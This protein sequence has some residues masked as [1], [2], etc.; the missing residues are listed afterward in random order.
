MSRSK[1]HVAKKFFDWVHRWFGLIAGFYFV[2][3]GLSGSFLVYEDDLHDIYDA[4]MRISPVST[5]APSLSGLV[6]ALRDHLGDPNAVPNRLNIPERDNANAIFRVE[7]KVDGEKKQ[8]TVFGDPASLKITGEEFYRDTISGFVFVFHHDLFWGSTG[9]T[10][11][12]VSGTLMLILLVTGLYL[13]WP[14]KGRWKDAFKFGRM[15]NAYQTNFEIHRVIGFYSLVLMILI[16]FTGVFISKPNWF[17]DVP[18]PP[19]RAEG[20]EAP[21]IDFKAIET[22]LREIG[23]PTRGLSFRVD[24]KTGIV[25]VTASGAGRVTLTASGEE[26][27]DAGAKPHPVRQWNRDVHG[28]AFWGELGRLLVFIS[29]ILP[30]VFYISGFY[31]WR[32]KSGSK[33][34][35][36]SATVEA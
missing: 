17:I 23:F 35:K 11:M 8:L 1:K 9:R 26:S 4:K 29:G 7:R 24:A 33:K 16:T 20:A 2:L 36:A 15:K 31:I 18:K 32:K 28:G 6:Q 19:K 22:K 13:W 12:G 25:G 27:L 21:V 30:L 34:G 14:K 3:L 5:E 10:I